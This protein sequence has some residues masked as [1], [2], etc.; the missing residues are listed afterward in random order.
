MVTVDY[1]IR[2]IKGFSRETERPDIETE[3]TVFGVD[4]HIKVSGDEFSFIHLF[5]FPSNGL[6]AGR[7]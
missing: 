4:I 7:E 3:Q 5:H 2:F 6:Q 1:P